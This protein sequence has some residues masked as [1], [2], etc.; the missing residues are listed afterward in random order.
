MKTIVGDFQ[1][2]V[3]RDSGDP[4]GNPDEAVEEFEV[5]VEYR[6]LPGSPPI[7]SGPADGWDPGSGDEVELTVTHEGKP[8]E[9]T[10]DEQRRAEEWALER[11]GEPED[12]PDR[13]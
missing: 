1:F 11:A 2:T 10:R 6:V 5:D 7:T 3:S 8:F 12:P 9:L 4:F 13:E